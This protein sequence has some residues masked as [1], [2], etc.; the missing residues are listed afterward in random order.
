MKKW[1]EIPVFMKNEQVKYYY[2][3]LKKK[4]QQI[5]IKRIF[6][7]VMAVGLIIVLAPFMLAISVAIKM[8][9]P[10]PVIFKQVRITTYGRKFYIYKFRTMVAGADKIGSKVTVQGDSRITKTG[11]FLRKYRL[12]EIPQLF[13]V[14]IGDMSFVGT[15]PEVEKYVHQYNDA[16]KATLLM[17]AGIT[18]LASIK[19][20][21]EDQ[22]LRNAENTDEEYV[23]IVLPEKMKYNLKA[24]EEFDIFSDLKTMIATV[25]AVVR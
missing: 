19:Y 3:I 6:D 7:L 15:R 2:N 22:L 8:D 10:G 13:N 20:K 1:D 14:L 4:E 21:D 24:L 9:S 11:E 5:R 17:P 18:S 25:F 16:M 12:D 23:K